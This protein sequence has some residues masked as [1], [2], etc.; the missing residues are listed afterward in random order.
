MAQWYLWAAVLLFGTL[1]LVVDG[2][3]QLGQRILHA[4]QT[5]QCIQLSKTLI[6]RHLGRL[7]V[8]NIL[9][10]SGM[11]HLGSPLVGWNTHQAVVDI[12]LG[13]CYL[14]HGLSCIAELIVLH[15]NHVT[16]HVQRLHA[17]RLVSQREV[18]LLRLG[19]TF[20]DFQQFFS[21]I[22]LDMDSV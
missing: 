14:L 3:C 17:D 9:S 13:L 5:N 4:T 20:I 6:N 18:V 10:K 11:Q 15:G 1:Y 2:M 7:L 12:R 21:G 8:R 22:I 16:E 19:G